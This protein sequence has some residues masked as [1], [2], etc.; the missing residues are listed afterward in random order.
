MS[1]KYI[2]GFF[3]KNEAIFC[4]S[5]FSQ[6]SGKDMEYLSDF[7]TVNSYRDAASY[8]SQNEGNIF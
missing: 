7:K 2:L 1:F 5:L 3:C 4:L 8:S 6:I